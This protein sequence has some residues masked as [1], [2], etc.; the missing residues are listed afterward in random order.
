MAKKLVIVE[1]P[2]KAKTIRKFLGSTYQVIASE[3]HVRD[4][5]K[6]Q[7]GVDIANDFEP[8]YI[9]IRGKGDV[10][11]ELKTA[12]K[13]ADVVYL[14]T[15]PDREGEAISWH[16]AIALGIAPDKASRITFNEITKQAVLAVLTNQ[17]RDFIEMSY[18]DVEAWLN[19]QIEATIN[20]YKKV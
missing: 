12:A 1:S 7:M 4:L 18:G 11:S 3:G 14:A 8:H 6:S 15:D 13:K 10:L 9:T 16:L 20:T 2:T 5:P 19:Q 17:A